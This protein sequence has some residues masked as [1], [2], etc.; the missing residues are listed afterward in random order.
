MSIPISQ[1]QKRHCERWKTTQFV[2]RLAEESYAV[3]THIPQ[4]IIH[5]THTV[6][7]LC[8]INSCVTVQWP[9]Q[10]LWKMRVKHDKARGKLCQN[11]DHKSTPCVVS[12]IT[13]KTKVKSRMH[14]LCS[15]CCGLQK[16][17]LRMKWHQIAKTQ[18][19]ALFI[20]SQKRILLKLVKRVW[21]WSEDI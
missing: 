15:M 5:Y 8:T 2:V 3:G 12:E 7:K 19:L 10:L 13:R 20:V 1:H 14:V 18:A 17:Y 9:Q 11:M 16:T 6:R 21:G 4:S